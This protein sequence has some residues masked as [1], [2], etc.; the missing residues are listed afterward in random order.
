LNPLPAEIPKDWTRWTFD[1]LEQSFT[2]LYQPLQATTAPAAATFNKKLILKE[3][4]PFIGI[5]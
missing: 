4:P 1:R 2:N 5:F 3:I